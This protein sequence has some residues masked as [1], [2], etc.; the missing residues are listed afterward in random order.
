MTIVET[1]DELGA[2]LVPERMTRLFYWF[3]EKGVER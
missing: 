1:G 2:G 3:D